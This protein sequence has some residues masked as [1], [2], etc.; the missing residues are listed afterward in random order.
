MI[1]RLILRLLKE[2][3]LSTFVLLFYISRWKGRMK[4]TSATIGLSAGLLVFVLTL[5]TWFQLAIHQHVDLGRWT[6]G[7]AAVAL[8][9]TNAYFLDI[10]GTGPAFERQF[11]GFPRRK[12][13]V[14]LLAAGAIFVGNFVWV[15]LTAPIY[16][17]AFGIHQIRP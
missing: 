8:S 13:I 14:L 5:W 9:A 1:I 7:G 3:Y 4:A 2:L 10:R 12:K 6:I 15:F 17:Q 16:Q 11:R